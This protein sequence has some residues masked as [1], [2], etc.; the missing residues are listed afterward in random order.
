M[1]DKRQDPSDMPPAEDKPRTGF[2]AHLRSA[3][4]LALADPYRLALIL[5]VNAAI[6][7]GLVGTAVILRN[8]KPAPKP[9]T[10]EDA[11]GALDRGNV[12]QAHSLAERLAAK[13]GVTRNEEGVPDFIFGTL[14]MKAAEAEPGK[15]RSEGFRLAALYLERSRQHGFPAQREA[16]GLYLLGKCLS[17]CGRWD[18]AAPVLEEALRKPSGHESELRTLLISALEGVRPPELDK[19]LAESKKLLADPQLGDEPRAEAVLEQ[20]RI[21]ICMDRRQECAAVLDK[22]PATLLL[23]G[24]VSVLRGRIALSEALAMRKAGDNAKQLSPEARAKFQLA[25]DWFRKAI[26][27]DAGDNRAARAANYL[28]GVCQSEQGD[29]P[30][31]IAQMERIG[32]RY[33]HSPEFVA[34]LLK[35]GEIYDHMG[36]HEESVRAYQKLVT[37]CSGV[38]EFHNPWISAAEIQAAIQN[39][40]REYLKAEKYRTALLFSNLLSHLVPKAE[41]LKQNAEVY[42]TWGQN[43]MDEAERLPPEQAEQRRKE[44]RTAFR[45]LG[46]IYA[47]L[48]S[49][50]FTSRD[51]PERLWNAATAYSAGHDF[52]NA[53]RMLRI[54]LHNESRVRH[55]Q[56]LVDLGE[57]ELSLGETKQAMRSFEE[58]IQQHPR[59]VAIYRARLLASRASIALGDLKQAENYLLENLHGDQLTPASKEWRDSLFAL[60]ELLHRVG[61]DAEAIVR[62]EEAVQRYPAM[63]RQSIAARYLLADSS[64]R[65]AATMLAGMAKE[66]S[67]AAQSERRAEIDLHF[68]RALEL[69]GA[70]QNELGRRDAED[71]TEQEKAMLRNARFALGDVHFEMQRYPEALRAYQSAANHYATKPGS[72]GRLLADRQRLSSPRPA[73]GGPYLAGAGPACLAADSARREFRTNDELQ[74]PTM[75]RTVGLTCVACSA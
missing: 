11:L 13:R 36:R 45:R 49:G 61:R 9:P 44:A 72:A 12:D 42:R 1:V 18:E 27:Q 23:R 35:Q 21:L 64:R 25:I 71:L 6:V 54:Y 58:C 67:S 55:A 32:T 33:P 57:A 48:A 70:L 51:Y 65:L 30:A 34:S 10:M 60:G 47:Q 62:L 38:D 24:L 14:A 19:A 41:A 4:S 69:Y 15:N 16:T 29:L 3:V 31:A 28:I 8:Y 50:L 39:A 59:D 43:L 74:P 66:V 52:R 17:L 73:G 56:A 2:A 46:D 40:C 7:G 22:A 53:A 26:S 75:G 68:R 37:A 63:H 20:A 5:A